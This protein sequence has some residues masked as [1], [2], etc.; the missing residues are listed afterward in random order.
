MANSRKKI[1]LKLFLLILNYHYFL[2]K[3]NC[4]NKIVQRSNLFRSKP[5][6]FEHA[7]LCWPSKQ[8]SSCSFPFPCCESGLTY[9]LK[10]SFISSCPVISFFMINV[11]YENYYECVIIDVSYSCLLISWFTGKNFG[12]YKNR[13]LILLFFIASFHS[14]K[15]CIVLSTLLN[16]Y[17]MKECNLICPMSSKGTSTFQ[18]K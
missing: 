1:F 12:F 10:L 6:Y 7:I 5:F 16:G 18:I 9:S 3:W 4:V 2:F 8:R 14:E 11:I 13:G 15:R 17:V